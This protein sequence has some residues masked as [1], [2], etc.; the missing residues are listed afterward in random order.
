MN[1]DNIHFNPR[2]LDGFPHPF[3]F[4]MGARELGKTTVIWVS[5]IYNGW[6]KDG[7]P[8]IYLTRQVAD[9]SE[10]LLTTIEDTINKF[11]ET[12]VRFRYTKTELKSGIVDI[13]IGDK[14]F[15][16]IV[17]LS[18]SLR[19]IK[20]A[21]VPGL[22]G[23]FMDEYIINP[24]TGERYVKDE[25]FKLKEAYTTW[26]REAPG[27]K[28]YFTANYY[29]LYNP[30]FA[31]FGIDTNALKVGATLTSELL[32]VE[33]QPLK[34]ELRDQIL[35]KNPLYQF[36][37]EYKAYAIGGEVINDKS[38]II[39]DK[40]H[41][42]PLKTLFKVGTKY[43]GVYQNPEFNDEL[44]FYVEEVKQ[45]SK[46]RQVLCVDLQDLA[47][48]CRLLMPGDKLRF[49][50]F[51]NAICN[52]DVGYSDINAYYTFIEVFKLL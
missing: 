42:Y 13:Y 50:R 2:N 7:R 48:N 21:V 37:E 17:A 16:R 9:I 30:L 29:S 22:K 31:T 45:V 19:R 44:S 43:Y 35:A 39:C 10:A 12:P 26:V 49:L 20:L 6:I 14:K 32:V 51:K 27:L 52:N 47:E 11:I 38:A 8:W 33:W 46:K 41:N 5:K 15:F 23:V 36:D 18:I 3:K 34:D 24:K 28:M 4:A 25:A 1:L 40:P